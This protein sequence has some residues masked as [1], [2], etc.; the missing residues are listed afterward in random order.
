MQDLAITS[1]RKN[2]EK[3]GLKNVKGHWNLSPEELQRITVE[4]GL[5]KETANGTLAINTGKFTGRSPQDRYLVKDDYTKDRVWW[6][7]INK[8]FD[9]DMFDTLQDEIVQC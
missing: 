8:P 6:G 2:L 9:P 5:G 1:N 3:Y 7:K 4:K